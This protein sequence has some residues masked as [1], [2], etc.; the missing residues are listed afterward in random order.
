MK[1]R[2]LIATD[3]D[4]Y[5]EHLSNHISVH[6]PDLIEVS[7]CKAPGR[8][9]EMLAETVYDVAL[10]EGASI[11]DADM[12]AVRLPL[13]LY[14]EDEGGA[15]ASGSFSTIRKYQRIST[16]VADVLQLYAH[17]SAG[18]RADGP[19]K[20]S[21]TAVWSPAGGVG[22]TTV[23][24]AYAAKK[25]AEGKQTLYLNLE[26][27]SSVP[28]YFPQTGKS[29]SAVFEMLENREGD[30]RTLIRGILKHDS[31]AGVAYL[32]RPENFDDVNILSVEDVSFLI[33]ACAGV[34]QELVI[35]MS[36]V[37]D[38]RARK[39]FEVSDRVLLVTDYGQATQ[40]KLT[41]FCTQHN[42]FSRI[43]AKTTLIVNKGATTFEQLAG[44]VV[45]LP[46]VS[47]S[48]VVTVYKTLS[49]TDF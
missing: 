31:A 23:A 25:K 36:C 21:I 41:Q 13:M 16:L 4:S 33:D 32:C 22:K 9:Q 49:N 19:D 1:I 26:P 34:T 28:A 24:L 18:D 27:F 43:K 38:A 3:D 15:A 29:I 39:V 47:S 20:A 17:V 6:H 30:V 48:D 2:L 5:A 45:R 40:T 44:S 10:F 42:V 11:R 35:D 7:V 8:L 14:S 12:G 46:Y 37:C